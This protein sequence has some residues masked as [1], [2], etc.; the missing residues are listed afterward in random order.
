M[1]DRDRGQLMQTHEDLRQNQKKKKKKSNEERVRQ[2]G[3]KYVQLK[4]NA[5]CER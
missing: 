1:G 2:E 3:E 4:K 5:I